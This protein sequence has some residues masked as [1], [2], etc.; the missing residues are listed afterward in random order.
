MSENLKKA[1]C[2]EQEYRMARQA[3]LLVVTTDDEIAVHRFAE[4]V[5]A[6]AAPAFGD[7]VQGKEATL[8][9]VDHSGEKQACSLRLVQDK[10]HP[11]LAQARTVANEMVEAFAK[12][13]FGGAA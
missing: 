6:D 3:G 13:H 9:W 4:M 12:K 11:L 8:F 1:A 10:N 7:L 2:T 5:R